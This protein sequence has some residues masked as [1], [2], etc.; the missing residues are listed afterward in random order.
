MRTLFT[1]L[2]LLTISTTST[3]TWAGPKDEE[4]IKARVAEFIGVF[5]KGDAKAAAAYFAEDATLVNPVGM[6]GTG[7]AEVEKIIGADIATILKGTQMEM[8]VVSVR[9]AGKD[10]A[11]VELEH[12]VKGM[13]GP[14]GKAMDMTFHVPALMV[15]KGKDWFVAEARPYAYLPP[16]PG[17]P[18]K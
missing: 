13:M 6:R 17:M 7:R 8:K 11:F 3:T 9:M 1:V 5:N 12:S 10:A 2:A 14:G 15:K 16:P 18:K 4:A